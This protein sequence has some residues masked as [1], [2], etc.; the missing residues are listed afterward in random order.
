MVPCSEKKH[1]DNI[2]IFFQMETQLLMGKSN[3]FTMKN[4]LDLPEA[5]KLVR[6]D[7]QDTI[8]SH[9]TLTLPDFHD[10][11]GPTSHSYYDAAGTPYSKWLQSSEGMHYSGNFHNYLIFGINK[12][13]IKNEHSFIKQPFFA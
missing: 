4:L 12:S 6:A 11:M 9:T 3:S 2:I 13:Q 8:G 7:N 10:V 5:S 1:I